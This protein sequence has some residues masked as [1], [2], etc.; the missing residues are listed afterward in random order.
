MH[1]YSVDELIMDARVL[2]LQACGTP[3]FDQIYNSGA[4]KR[5]AAMSGNGSGSGGP[6]LH[7]NQDAGGTPE[8]HH[9]IKGGNGDMEKIRVAIVDDQANGDVREQRLQ[10]PRLINT[11]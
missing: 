1:G 8:H 10:K 5:T 3:S 7:S 6:F 9:R 11:F 2:A 4:W